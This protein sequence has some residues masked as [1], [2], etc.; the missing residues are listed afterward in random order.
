MNLKM[1]SNKFWIK[2][3]KNNNILKEIVL[4]NIKTQYRNSV[5]G[6]LWTI[7]NPLLNMI[8]LSIVFSSIFRQGSDVINYPIYLL[9]G[10][11]LFNFFRTGTEQGLTSLVHN[12]D[13]LKKVKI[14]YSI[15]PTSTIFSSLV[16]FGF[17]LIALVFVMI[18][19]QQPFYPTLLMI[20]AMMPSLILFTLGVSMGLSAMYV[21]FRDVQHLYG[22]LLTLWMYATPIFY[23]IESVSPQV[24]T[25]IKFNPLHHYLRYF[26]DIVQIGT[27]PGLKAHLICYGCGI[28][29]FLLGYSFFHLTKKKFILYI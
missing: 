12:S 3:K 24:Q 17:S 28:I 9:T 27:I 5:L 20:F 11:I 2:A 29:V 15:F 18:I 1:N 4:K 6:I 21:F 10:N 23:S 8:V 13:L 19:L 22:V 7:L 26:R 25:F 16:N 14:S